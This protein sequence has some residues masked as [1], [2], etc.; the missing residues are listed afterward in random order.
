MNDLYTI[1]KKDE[2]FRGQPYDCK[3]GKRLKAT[4][5]Y[6]TIGYGYNLDANELPEDIAEILLKRKVE[7]KINSLKKREI[8]IIQND[9]RSI[10]IICMAY[11]MG[12]T[13]LLKFKTTL[14]YYNENKFKECA[15]QMLKSKWARI[16]SPTRA[17][18]MAYMMETGKLHE[19]Y[20]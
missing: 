9:L 5:G 12:V 14:K 17:K 4:V 8:K 3:T 7:E 15:K 19:F 1:L 11:Q 10:V 13:G 16:D 6:T 2:G 18:R 20:K